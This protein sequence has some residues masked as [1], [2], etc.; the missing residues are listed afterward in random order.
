VLCEWTQFVYMRIPD[1]FLGGGGGASTLLCTFK[2]YKTKPIV[3][4]ICTTSELMV[5]LLSGSKSPL[6]LW[7]QMFI[8]VFMKACH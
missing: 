2:M 4:D 6:F 3:I 7:A 1:F 8:M 5:H